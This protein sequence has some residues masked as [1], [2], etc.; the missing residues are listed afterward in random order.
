MLS[1]NDLNEIRKAINKEL[2]NSKGLK[3]EI[4]SDTLLGSISKAI[5][6]AI[7]QYDRL[8]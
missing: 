6:S 5:V 3:G 1:E 7:K 2:N 8:R 4:S